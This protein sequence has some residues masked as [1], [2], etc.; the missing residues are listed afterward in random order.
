MKLITGLGNPGRPYKDTR[1][2]VGFMVLDRIAEDSGF[3]FKSGK[4]EYEMAE[5]SVSGERVIFLKPTTYMNLSGLAVQA[6]V[7]YYKISTA[8]LLVIC[9]DAALPLGK[10]RARKE[11]SDGGQK[12][13]RSIT[14]QLQ[15]DRF[16][17]LR[18]GIGR[19]ERMDLS[20]FVLSRFND[21][22]KPA[23]TRVLETSQKA[24][25]D[26][27]SRGIDYVMNQYNGMTIGTE[28]Q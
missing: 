7:Q 9:D 26:F 27:I 3:R 28:N 13:L 6:V 2:N 12:G 18:I 5:C 4:G 8:D 25:M 14:E 1:H 23:L 16:P 24:V 22:E 17:R 20:D 10:I 19:N 15:D 11:G 21:D